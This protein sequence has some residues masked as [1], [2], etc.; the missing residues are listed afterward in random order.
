M[1]LVCQVVRRAAVHNNRGPVAVEVKTPVAAASQ[2]PCKRECLFETVIEVE[3][4]L[5]V[6]V[7]G[8]CARALQRLCDLIYSAVGVALLACSIPCRRER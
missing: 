5:L 3:R 2:Q 8:A 1:L 4:R 6:V 7:E